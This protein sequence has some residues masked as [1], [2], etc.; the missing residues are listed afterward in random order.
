MQK[1]KQWVEN[2]QQEKVCI[3][4]RGFPGSGKS[5]KINALLAKYGGDHDHIFSTDNYFIPVAQQKKRRGEHVPPDAETQEYR[6]NWRVEKLGA[7]HAH[8][9]QEFQYAVDL[10]ISPVIVDNTNITTR[11]FKHYAEYADKAGYTVKLEE[12]D[13]PWWNEARPL[14]ADKKFN[15]KKLEDFASVLARRNTHGV[16]LATI[17]KMIG[18]WQDDIDVDVL[19]GKKEPPKKEH[20]SKYQADHD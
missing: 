11:D 9:F 3:I 4:L 6:S 1:F 13:S 16:P 19:L 15:A 8:N 10:G 2:K 17:Q 7:A 5:T 14:L 18:R 20:V 12:P